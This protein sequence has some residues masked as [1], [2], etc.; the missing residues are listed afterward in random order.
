MG[1][2][3]DL[4]VLGASSPTATRT[5]RRPTWATAEPL[6]VGADEPL[7]RVARLM[8]EHHTSH[9]L[10]LSTASGRPAGVLS[11]LDIAALAGRG[12]V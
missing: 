11:T 3:P 10:V 6:A 12:D 8:S 2:L 1:L 5:R 7:A 4:D 9:V